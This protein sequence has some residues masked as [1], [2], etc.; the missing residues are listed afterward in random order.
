MAV[1]RAAPSRIGLD[2]GGTQFDEHEGHDDPH[3]AEDD[4]IFHEH[5]ATNVA[6]ESSEAVQRTRRRASVRRG[7]VSD[8]SKTNA[9]R[10]PLENVR[11]AEREE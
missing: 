9:R 8:E 10:R 2:D 11:F 6:P 7:H 4:R 5:G 3:Q 1:E